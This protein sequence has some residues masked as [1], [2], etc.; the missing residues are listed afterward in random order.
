MLLAELI[1]EKDYIKES[2]DNLRN[3]IV[4]LSNEGK[5]SADVIKKHME[6]LE[7]LY[8][9]HQRFS[10]SIGRTQ[11]H[12]FIKVNS[13]K[14]SISDAIIIKESMLEKLQDI[15]II[16]S[17]SPYTS[18]IDREG[19]CDDIE[20]IRLDIKTMEGEIDFGFWNVEVS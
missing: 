17:G 9:K 14:L 2:I 11:G 13:A 10:I 12:A 18:C 15:E 16:L 7:E 20:N 8:N 19:L 1:K 4:S 5:D 6:E 3:R